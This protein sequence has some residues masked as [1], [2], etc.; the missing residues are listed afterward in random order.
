MA[1]LEQK[2][3]KV[4]YGLDIGTRSVVGTVG[5]MNDGQFN[6][7]AQALEKHETRAMLDGQ[8]HDIGKV[9]ATIRK[10]TERLEQQTDIHLTDVCI[11]AA[12]RVL[13]TVRT[14]Y[15]T[16]YPDGHTITDED[17]YN[18]DSAAVGKAYKEFI[19]QNTSELKF[20]LVGY[21]VMHYFLDGYQILWHDTLMLDS[22]SMKSFSLASRIQVSREHSVPKSWFFC[23]RSMSFRIFMTC[24]RTS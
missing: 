1:S 19:D 4:V 21:S 23:L 6:V 12:G 7:I 3:Q 24:G 9:G 2:D 20:Y 11:A 15:D 18:L 16:E 13:R 5:Y 10:V 22:L 17:I 14:T 8:I